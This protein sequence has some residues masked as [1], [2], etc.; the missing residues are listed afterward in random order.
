MRYLLLLALFAPLL[1]AQDSEPLT[2]SVPGNRR[3]TYLFRADF[4][5]SVT[6]F[7]ISANVNTPSTQG[8]VVRL[9]DLDTMAGSGS[10][11]PAGYDESIVPGTGTANAALSG[12]FDGVREFVVEIES[13]GSGSSFNGTLTLSAGT[14]D[15]VSQ[16]QLVLSATGLRT[17]VSRLGFFSGTTTPGGI[18][19]AG[20]QLDLGPVSRTVFVRFEC[21]G[22]NLDRMELIDN[23]GGSATILA[24]IVQGAMPDATT[25][26]VTGSGVRTMRVN[27]RGATGLSGSAAWSVTA[28][29]GVLLDR[30][31][32]TETNGDEDGKC[33]AT[34]AG[35]AP[36]AAVALFVALAAGAVRRPENRAATSRQVR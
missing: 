25:V 18:T 12:N 8:L 22:I 14:L 4:G 27:A 36:W 29:T 16:D 21:D 34:P 32:S 26:A 2:G 13:A 19:A 9:I 20:F 17:T 24:T 5:A 23:T 7:S 15:F 30:V 6:S 33:A 31:Q 28:P 35:S 3:L 10:V 11:N 1:A